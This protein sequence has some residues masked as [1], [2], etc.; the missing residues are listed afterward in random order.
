MRRALAQAAWF[1]LV[2]P[3]CKSSSS[4]EGEPKPAPAQPAA[5][6]PARDAGAE[7]VTGPDDTGAAPAT[8]GTDVATGRGGAVTSAE[9]HATEVGISILKKGG[10]AV[11]AAVAV[12]L[13][14]S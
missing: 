3:A 10:N 5:A 7:P 2:L 6:T 11:D 1:L 14:L 8:T 12:G 9:K 4:H 13:A